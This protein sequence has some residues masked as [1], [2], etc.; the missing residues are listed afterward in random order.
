[1]PFMRNGKALRMHLDRMIIE[2]GKVVK[3]GY[4]P[5]TRLE[6]GPGGINTVS[7]GFTIHDASYLRMKNIQLGYTFPT[8]WMRS[9]SISGARIYVSGQNL[10]TFTK[11]PDGYDPEVNDTPFHGHLI[12]GAAGWSYPQVKS[13]TIGLDINLN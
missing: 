9:L 2:N 3:Q 11:F 12:G 8:A 5:E 4:F 1:M 13:Y 10:L 6:G 7:S